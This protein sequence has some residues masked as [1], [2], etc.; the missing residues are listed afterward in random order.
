MSRNKIILAPGTLVPGGK[1]SFALKVTDKCGFSGALL[2]KVQMNAPPSG[3]TV[4]VSPAD[5]VALDTLFEFSAP[6][7]SDPEALAGL[8]SSLTEEVWGTWGNRCGC[9]NKV[10]DRVR[11]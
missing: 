10:A 9:A 11:H 6:G 4:L 1:Y 8:D 5:G 2:P 7:W 3:G